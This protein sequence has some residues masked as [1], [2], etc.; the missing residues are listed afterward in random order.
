MAHVHTEAVMY[1]DRTKK[2]TRTIRAIEATWS[3]HRIARVLR[4]QARFRAVTTTVDA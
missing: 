2:F 3:W 4:L 1:W